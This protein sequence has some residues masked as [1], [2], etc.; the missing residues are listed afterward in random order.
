MQAVARSEAKD[1]TDHV[2]MALAL[3]LFDPRR[4]D[5]LLQATPKA[6]NTA[7]GLL[8]RGT[9]HTLIGC[10]DRDTSKIDAA[11]RDIDCSRLLTEREG[12]GLGQQ[13]YSIS[14]AFEIAR[15]RGDAQNAARYLSGRPFTN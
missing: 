13:L 12:V 11:I 8:I 2:L 3:M 5:L 9:V 10:D 6:S 4:S 1:D 7:A 14:V 15:S